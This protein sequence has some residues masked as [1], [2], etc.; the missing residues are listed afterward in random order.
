MGELL[1]LQ[2]V[3]SADRRAEK[4]PPMLIKPDA[5]EVQVTV[6]SSA[7]DDVRSPRS[8][9]TIAIYA[10]EVG[11]YEAMHRHLPGHALLNVRLSEPDP[12]TCSTC[13]NPAVLC[14]S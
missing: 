13:S 7:I 10:S 6:T 1:S 14:T 9:G 8:W 11:T 12:C 5:R 2:V 4:Q 3:G